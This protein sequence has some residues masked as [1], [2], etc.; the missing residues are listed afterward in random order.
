M[1]HP[2]AL[3]NPALITDRAALAQ[4]LRAVKEPRSYADLEA[5]ANKLKSLSRAGHADLSGWGQEHPTILSKGSVTDWFSGRALP[6]AAKPFTYLTVCEVPSTDLASW[7]EAVERV[8][9]LA[10][11]AQALPVPAEDPSRSSRSRFRTLLVAAVIAALGVAVIVLVL[12]VNPQPP[13]APESRPDPTPPALAGPP[14]SATVPTPSPTAPAPGAVAMP[15]GTTSLQVAYDLPG[16]CSTSYTVSG[17]LGDDPRTINKTLWIVTQLAADPENGSPNALYYAKTP[18][19]VQDGRIM[20]SV[21][22]NTESGLRRAR[23]ILVASPSPAANSDLQLSKDSGD[24]RDN[25]YTDG[26]RTRLQLGNVEIATTAI[27][28]Q[29]C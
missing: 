15:G 6:S 14:L 29:R 2:P 8:R 1:S 20:I 25:R 12:V 22:A 27:V 28:E 26:R 19:P 16:G 24:A 9:P 10:P 11:P 5:A 18:V 13:P 17:G 7:L 4:A 3:P 21:P 23:V